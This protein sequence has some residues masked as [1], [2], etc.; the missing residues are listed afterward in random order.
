MPMKCCEGGKGNGQGGSGANG[1]ITG[2]ACPKGLYSTLSD[3]T[4]QLEQDCIH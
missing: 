1:T 2:K 4:T 3:P